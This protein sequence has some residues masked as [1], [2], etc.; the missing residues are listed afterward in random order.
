[1][2][3]DGRFWLHAETK[4][5]AGAGAYCVIWPGSACD[6]DKVGAQAGVPLEASIRNRQGRTRR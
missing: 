4:T 5:P 1:M 3:T 6:H 2:V